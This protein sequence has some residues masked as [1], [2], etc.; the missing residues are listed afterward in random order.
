MEPELMQKDILC[1]R[2]R[3]HAP[4]QIIIILDACRHDAF[5]AVT[6]HSNLLKTISAGSTTWEWAANTFTEFY[7][8]VIY[9]SGSPYIAAKVVTE[10]QKKFLALEHFPVVDDVWDWGYDKDTDTVLPEVLART[11][12]K[13]RE[14]YPGMTI[15]AHFMQPHCPFIGERHLLL[16]DWEAMTGQKPPGFPSLREVHARIG[17]IELR[18]MYLDNLK[19]VMRVVREEILPRF[20]KVFITSDH[21]EGFGEND[22]YGHDAGIR[23]PE[24]LEVP[25]F[26]HVP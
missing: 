13:T 8:N 7:E 9:V 25:W 4:G 3:D 5:E 21:G 2:L 6:N 26:S 19:R 11:V 15:I 14:S 12:L 17:E 24:L 22:I 23:T 18:A 10:Q 20:E 1:G 16:S